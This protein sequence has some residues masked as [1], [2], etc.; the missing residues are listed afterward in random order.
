MGHD[1]VMTSSP[2]LRLVV[3]LT[4]R[5]GRD[6]VEGWAHDG[7]G[8]AYLKV[9]VAAPPVD[10]QA[11]AALEA[12]IAKRLKRPGRSVR[13]VAGDHGRLKQLEI[14]DMATSALHAVFGAPQS[15]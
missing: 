8:L 14:D 15:G 3:R 1:G 7:Q 10:G 9:R 12:L 5:G 13:I 4:P 2:P 6:A 11:N